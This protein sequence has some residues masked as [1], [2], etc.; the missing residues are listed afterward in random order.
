MFSF[1]ELGV[2]FE[3]HKETEEASKPSGIYC[4]ERLVPIL[5]ALYTFININNVGGSKEKK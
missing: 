4:Q 3:L 5:Q 2:S 1:S